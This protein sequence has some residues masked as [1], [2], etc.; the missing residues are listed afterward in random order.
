MAKG[1]EI[2]GL[3]DL[4]EQEEDLFEDAEDTSSGWADS[5]D[6]GAGWGTADGPITSHPPCPGGRYLP[7]CQGR[8]VDALRP[9]WPICMAGT[10]PPEVMRAARRA[11]RAS[12]ASL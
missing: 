5:I 8:A 2:P 11:M 6:K 9:A 10:A 4:M 3:G 12:C 1:F 7:P